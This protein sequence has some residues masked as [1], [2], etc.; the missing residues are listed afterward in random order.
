[1]DF[2]ELKKIL[3]VDN[4]I[5]A[6]QRLDGRNINDQNLPYDQEAIPKMPSEHFFKEGNIFI[7]KHHRYSAMPPHTHEFVEFNYMLSGTCVQYVN[8]KKITLQPGE[9]LLLDKDIVQRIDPLA[10]NDILINILLRDDSITT[11]IV[12]NMVKSNGLLN[13]FLLNAARQAASHDE[14]LHFHC[15]NNPDVQGILHKMILEYYNKQNYYMRSLNLF[16]SI[17]LIELTRDL[18]EEN[19]EKGH[20]NQELLDILRYIDL[21]FT[22]LTLKKLAQRFGY[23]ANY[24]S[25]KLKK[26]TGHSF[27]E[28]LNSLRYKTALDLMKETDKSFEE[29]AYEIGFETLPSLY[30]LFAKYT[31]LTPKELKNSVLFKSIEKN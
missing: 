20:E 14:V 28:L 26:E 17:L 16:L 23:N 21:H 22:D 24:L 29:I 12:V 31:K 11:D 7:N 6:Q 2:Q 5:E 15:G 8:D 4:P 1:M 19:L 10:E 9:L 18:E 3:W 13:E 30:K 25:N 27:Q